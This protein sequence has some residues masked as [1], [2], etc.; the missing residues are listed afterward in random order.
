MPKR[1][2][3][4]AE[5]PLDIFDNPRL[6]NAMAAATGLEP[7]AEPDSPVA[8]AAPEPA[9]PAPEEAP[10]PP[11]TSLRSVPSAPVSEPEPAPSSRV[12]EPAAEPE[13]APKAAPKEPSKARKGRAQTEPEAEPTPLPEPNVPLKF[14]VPQN[15]RSEFQTFKAELSAALGGV[16]LDDS[17]LGRPLLEHFLLDQR[18]RILEAA[19]A[20][21]GELRRPA[22]GDAVGMAE[23]DHT[24][25]EI[26]REAR[27][28]RRA[29]PSSGGSQASA[30][31][32][33]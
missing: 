1:R 13:E 3:N 10:K 15:L 7:V 32:E 16:A 21:R 4:T 30:S 19:G 27:K 2:P 24:L 8:E 5:K 22:N 25:G 23:F 6:S 18:D 17:N 31:A 29:S 11:A 28:R 20:F 9:E 26:F 14:R 33:R 12:S